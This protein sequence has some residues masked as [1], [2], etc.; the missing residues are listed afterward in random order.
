MKRL[1]WMTG[2]LVVFAGCEGG[3]LPT[4]PSTPPPSLALS[5]GSS[6]GNA[7]FFFLSLVPSAP[8]FSGTFNPDLL[9][10]VEV[11]ALTGGACVTGP[12]VVQFPPSEV[13]L[14]L[15]A[16]LYGVS[17]DTGP[18]ALQLGTDYRIR[19]FAG[20]QELGFRDVRPVATAGEV[21][22]P[23]TPDFH[24]FV[25]GTR[26]RARF[27]IENGAVCAPGVPPAD[28]AEELVD[29]AAGG[30]VQTGNGDGVDFP[31]QG[32]SQQLVNVVVQPCPNG[33]LPVDIPLFGPC[34]DVTLTPGLTQ[35]LAIPAV[36]SACSPLNTGNLSHAQEDLLIM[37][38]LDGSTIE[39][40]PNALDVC[41]TTGGRAPGTGFMR[42]ARAVRDRVLSLVRPTPL[43]ARRLDRGKGGS[44]PLFSQFQFGLPSKMDKVAATDNQTAPAGSPVPLPP[45]V[46]VTDLNG[47]DVSGATVT[48]QVAS[49]GGS[50]GGTT[51][52]VLTGADGIASV[53]WT[54]GT[55]GSNTLDATGRGIADPVTN[56]PRSSFDPFHPI[57]LGDP[58]LESPV[59]LATGLVTFQATACAVGSGSAT[60]DGTI[61]PTEWACARTFDFTANLSGGSSTPARLFVMNDATDLYL[62][63]RVQRSALDKV[64]TLRFDF[65][66]DGDGMAE[67]GDDVLLLASSE[68]FLDGFL[69]E[70][71]ANRRQSSCATS[72][73]GDRHAP[74]TV[75]GAGALSNDGVHTMYE[76]RHPL[77]NMDDLH[78]ISVQAG[79]V[80]GLFLTLSTGQ[81]AQG[82]TQWPGFRV[83]QPV[84]IV[85]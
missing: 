60:I 15:D 46:H 25:N 13:D 4:V 26:L 29:L 69:D 40:L 47:D 7:H 39:A 51:V 57:D 83:Y 76:L 78:D 85:P 67:E 38:R 62:A 33:N 79:D 11:C 20:G 72:D 80:L 24:V 1:G 8:S 53:G 16:E 27:R 6:G 81:G 44:T 49:G 14:G 37:H 45:A 5:D 36:V 73:T 58:T 65:D 22:N 41:P 3:S 50:I 48:F 54:L 32:G 56:G 19:V 52:P 42:L 17:W 55:V 31:A 30:T 61:D 63:V 70:R 18:S 9:V 74:G 34:L 2:V 43:L 10:T 21:P 23:Q 12:P 68:G 82:N 77:D 66:N 64:N 28:C 84:P 71:C 59:T 75:D 35:P